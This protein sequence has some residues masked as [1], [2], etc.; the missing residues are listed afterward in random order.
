MVITI[1]VCHYMR[2]SKSGNTKGF[3]FKNRLKKE[4]VIAITLSMK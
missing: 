1:R 2:N 3:A 4:I